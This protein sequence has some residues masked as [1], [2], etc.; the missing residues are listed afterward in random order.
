MGQYCNHTIVQD[1]MIRVGALCLGAIACI[2][3]CGDSDP[4]G[5][6]GAQNVDKTE[7][8]MEFP[9]DS[10][11]DVLRKLYVAL[12]EGRYDWYRECHSQYGPKYD[13]LL[14][15]WYKAK[16]LA[17]AMTRDLRD[18][19]GPDAREFFER[20]SV[21]EQPT[22]WQEY[23]KLQFIEDSRGYVEVYL[24][25]PT[26]GEPPYVQM[27]EHEGKWCVRKSFMEINSSAAVGSVIRDQIT[28][29][30]EIRRSLQSKTHTPT[31][32]SLVDI[33][34]RNPGLWR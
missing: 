3:G 24:P 21:V 34:T 4:V 10:P 6:P 28:R 16:R 14:R 31:I 12:D 11:D 19:F 18:E 27:V 32:D 30:K 29:M 25:G 22:E 7:P 23:E 20:A 1:H 2:C 8:V 13:K 9:Q 26:L 17:W 15:M 33:W 5:R